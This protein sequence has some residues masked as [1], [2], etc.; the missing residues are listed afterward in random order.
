M[1]NIFPRTAA[2]SLAIAASIFCSLSADAH[3]ERDS[4]RG[5]GTVTIYRPQKD[6][7]ATFRYRDSKGRYDE[8]AMAEIARFFRCRL[9]GE[10]HE[11]DPGLVEILDSIED[12]FHAGE[13]RLISEYSKRSFVHVDTGD[14][15]AWG[16]G[17]SRK[18]A[19]TRTASAKK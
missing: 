17:K 19:R 15:R 2:A 16:T 10:E 12:H 4:A 5:D 11:I 18:K 6:E 7:R 14:V 9:T 1:P 3:A 13:I 8:E